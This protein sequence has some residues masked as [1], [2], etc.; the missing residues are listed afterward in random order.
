[1]SAPLYPYLEYCKNRSTDFLDQLLIHYAKPPHPN[2]WQAIHYAVLNGGKRIRPALVYATG[3]ILGVS[4]DHCDVPAAA[5]ELIHCYSLIHD[6]LPAMDNDDLRRGKPSCHKA[7]DEAT[8]ILAG[9]ALQSLAFEILSHADIPVLSP[10]QKI[11]MIQQLSKASGFHGMVGGQALDMQSSLNALN[12]DVLCNIH[13]KKTGALIQTA[14]QFAVI[15]ADCQ[16]SKIVE[17]LENYAKCLGLSFQIQD[18]ILDVEGS[19][20]Q[21]GKNPGKDSEQNKATFPELMGLDAAKKYANTLHHEALSHLATVFSLE[22][23]GKRLAEISEFFIR[24]LG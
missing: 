18:D 17:A 16:D 1:M 13:L 11:A 3:E 6:D 4:P 19:K 20:N 9:D 2:L 22:E 8:A 10:T 23:K 5:I 14:I 12:T 21:L 24:R 7:F 15:A